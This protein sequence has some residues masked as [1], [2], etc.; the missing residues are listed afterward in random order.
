MAMDITLAGWVLIP[1]G[2][3]AFCVLPNWLYYLAIFLIPFS[4]TA[5]VNLTVGGI[6]KGMP[7]V[8]FIGSLWIV[9]EF[10]TIV[11]PGILK[12]PRHVRV[13]GATC[14]LY[15]VILVCSLS[16]PLFM[17]GDFM[18]TSPRLDAPQVFPLS[19]SSHN[20]TQFIYISFW[21]AM[22]W[23]IVLHNQNEKS[24]VATIRIFVMSA[25]F[26]GCWGVLQWASYKFG[27]NYPSALFNS[28]SSEFAQGYTGVLSKVGVKRITSVA[29]EASILAQYL[30]CVLPLVF[31]A[32]WFKYP[33][34]SIV[35]DRIVLVVLLL[36]LLLSTSSTAYLGLLLFALG[37]P[38]LL[39]LKGRRLLQYASWIILL[40]LV[41]V[42]LLTAL[43]TST[44]LSSLTTPHTFSMHERLYTINNA[45]NSFLES[46]LLGL[47][48]GSIT[49]HD[50]VVNL[51]ANS[52]LIGLVGF[53][54]LIIG[55]LVNLLSAHITYRFEDQ[56]SVFG[57]G[58]L[59]SFMLI[60]AVSAF[61]GFGY[62]FGHFWLLLALSVSVGM[63][64]S[65]P[66]T[67]FNRSSGTFDCGR[68]A[69]SEIK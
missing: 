11:H 50:L 18:I 67:T 40:G 33:I 44:A 64:M 10:I 59:S 15:L 19:F 38:I 12:I 27:F 66:M 9:R 48:W 58:I 4:A 25:M 57:A 45:W 3:V 41:E 43:S 42:F 31:S 68:S 21:I 60:I 20:I 5:V 52:G 63:L 6:S 23:L 1:F 24:L 34:F 32:A 49:S 62:V 35:G 37:F 16:I 54:L 36:V 22:T 30:L 28:S 14:S 29:V 26:V 2:L 13:F 17:H 56:K 61:S 51:L 39:R 8:L 47:G 7:A 55:P 65:S 53:I 69:E 46:P